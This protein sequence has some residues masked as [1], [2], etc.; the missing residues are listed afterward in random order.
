MRFL[1]LIQWDMRH[2]MH[3]ILWVLGFVFGTFLAR[4]YGLA[5]LEKENSI[6]VQQVVEPAGTSTISCSQNLAFGPAAMDCLSAN[7]SHRT[8][9]IYK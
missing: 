6:S 3:Q 8:V 9:W 2:D 7:T 4:G 1:H 5:S